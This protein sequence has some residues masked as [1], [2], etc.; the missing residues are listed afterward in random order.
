[1]AFGAKGI[2]GVV[3]PYMPVV[4]TVRL[5]KVERAPKQVNYSIASTENEYGRPLSQFGTPFLPMSRSTGSR[6]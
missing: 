1:M 2:P 5:E 4:Y 3:D 6:R